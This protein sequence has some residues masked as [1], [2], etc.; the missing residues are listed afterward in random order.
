[1]V[2]AVLAL[3]VSRGF[4]QAPALTAVAT[5]GGRPLARAAYEE[6][7]ARSEAESR[8]RLGDRYNDDIRRLLRRRVL[9]EMIRGELLV[10]EARRLK[11]SVPAAEVEA[12]IRRHPFFMTGGQFDE[13]KYQKVKAANSPAYQA[14]VAEIRSRLAGRKLQAQVQADF[15]PN[16]DS[17]R[18]RIERAGGRASIQHLPLRVSDFAPHVAPFRESEVHEYY[19][20]HSAEFARPARALVTA[21]EV[22]ASDS[23]G[24]PRSTAERAQSAIER[25][26]QGESFELVGAEF[27]AVRT[28]AVLTPNSTPPYWRGGPEDLEAALR[29]APGS[30]LPR[31]VPGEHGLLV[32]RVDEMREAQVAPLREVAREIRARLQAQAIDKTYDSRLRALYEERRVELRQP[33]YRVRY[34]IVD[35]ARFVPATPKTADLE[36]YHQAHMSEFSDYDPSSGAIRTQPLSEVRDVVT[37]G[38]TTENRFEKARAATEKIRGAWARGRRDRPAEKAAEVRE[39]GPTPLAV[40]LAPDLPGRIVGDSLTARGG[41]RGVG[42]ARSPGGWIVFHVLEEIPAYEPPFEQMREALRKDLELELQAEAARGARALFDKNPQRFAPGRT[43]YVGEI[44]IQLKPVIDIRLTRR[45]VERYHQE[46]ID[47]YSAT[48]Q[49]A[50]R[51]IL[52]SPAGPDAASDQA[53]RRKAEDVL[54]RARAGEDFARL[55]RLYSDDPPTRDHGGE[56]GLFGRGTMLEPFERAS[57]ALRPGEISDLVKT[58]VGYHIIKCIDYLPAVAEP[59]AR[60]YSNVGADLAAERADQMAR[61][62]ADS[63]IAVSRTPA[64][65]RATAHKLGLAATPAEYAPFEGITS[66]SERAMFMHELTTIPPGTLMNRPRLDKGSGWT[67]VWLDSVGPA[68]IPT[69]ESVQQTVTEAYRRELSAAAL[70]AKK[71]ELDSL[72][73]AGW[74]LDS[75]GA[76]FG[77]LERIPDLAPGKGVQGLGGVAALDSLVFGTNAAP[78]LS[79]GQTSGWVDLPRGSTRVSLV[80]LTRLPPEAVSRRLDSETQR[81]IEIRLQDYFK[82]LRERF[83]VSIHDTELRETMLPAV[84]ASTLR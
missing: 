13:D 37:Q 38:W 22:A 26:R 67:V 63:I 48:E 25:I 52:I 24:D 23:A 62:L 33:A 70:E 53:A 20:T 80:E 82:L 18:A 28:D 9:E 46:H 40:P 35:T 16:R 68:R 55:A 1:V 74:S 77:G 83:P 49:V 6:Q 12:E 17:L 59:L 7:W 8:R 30:V 81:A 73:A 47:E 60:L 32:V 43:Y 51:H 36:R 31:P 61:K 19:R 5:V 57:F 78:V 84:P 54:R 79:P 66:T 34:A 39:P 15:T 56:I 11:T 42:V 27:G 44:Q 75:L 3:A 50:V 29:A 69:F 10:L 65:A 64:R 76:A 71:A 41:A 21:F 14:S 45:E 58:E 72:A 2:I 4:A